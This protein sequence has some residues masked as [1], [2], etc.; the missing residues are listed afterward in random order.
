MKSMWVKN[1]VLENK[2]HNI[3]KET[4]LVLFT[5]LLLKVKTTTNLK[6]TSADKDVSAPKLGFKSIVTRSG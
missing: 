5:E 3:E 4:Q 2:R 6:L 1:K